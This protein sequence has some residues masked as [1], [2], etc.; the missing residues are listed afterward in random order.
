LRFNAPLRE[1]NNISHIFSCPEARD[2]NL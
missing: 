1:N 2:S